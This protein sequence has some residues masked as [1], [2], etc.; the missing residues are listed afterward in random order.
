ME[1]DTVQ[2]QLDGVWHIK[3]LTVENLAHNPHY[4]VIL[5]YIN[6][7]T[8]LGELLYYHM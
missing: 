8:L 1:G 6:V 4:T 5:V 2:D 3:P 7:I